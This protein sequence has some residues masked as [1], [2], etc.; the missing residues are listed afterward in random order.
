M[1]SDDEL[2][3]K[4]HAQYKRWHDGSLMEPALLKIYQSIIDK[5]KE[6]F[7]GDTIMHICNNLVFYGAC[8]SRE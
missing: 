6:Y 4:L 8:T 5:K 2:R 1:M 3:E 7:L